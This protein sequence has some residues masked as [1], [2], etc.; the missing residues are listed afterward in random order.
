MDHY[1]DLRLGSHLSGEEVQSAS[2]IL[3]D[4]Y[5]RWQTN[6]KNTNPI[7]TDTSPE[8]Y[9]RLLV[10]HQKEIA[11]YY[12]KKQMCGVF[13]HSLSPFYDQYP[14]RKLSY[15]GVKPLQ[16]GFRPLQMIFFRYAQFMREQGEDVLITSD[17]DQRTLNSLL[18]SV[19]F[20]EVV[21][22]NETYYLLSHLLFRR[23]FSAAKVANDFVIDEI[24]TCDGK[25]IRR[26]KK[27]LKLQTTPMDFY[28][29]Y[30]QQQAKRVRRSIPEA[31]REQLFS[32]LQQADRGMYFISD[33]TSVITNPAEYEEG[34]DPKSALMGEQGA[35][36]IDE[37]IVPE[38]NVFYL[39]PKNEAELDRIAAKIPI[40][41]GFFD[42]LTF[43]FKTLSSFF[44][45]TGALPYE[46]N[47]VLNRD[48]HQ[49]IKLR[50]TD[51]L[52]GLIGPDV[53]LLEGRTKVFSDGLERTAY[54]FSGPYVDLS[55]RRFDLRKDK[56]VE[57]IF[58][59]RGDNPAPVIYVGK[60]IYE[61]LELRKLFDEAQ[62][63]QTPV[64][65][66]DMGN[67][68]TPWVSEN[69]IRTHGEGNP[70]FSVINIRDYYQIPVMLEDLG[71]KTEWTL[72]MRVR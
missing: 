62:A 41:P 28:A 24:I 26:N 21:D 56:M 8:V 23:V 37:C 57:K 65:V 47:A 52:E 66:L 60:Q 49:H 25:A 11:L 22:R 20:R 39:L 64:L 5:S 13:V 55:N 9:A 4:A 14:V 51:M 16:R 46:V 63:R 59:I 1:F 10:K 53:E 32:A 48:L 61:G 2:R 35:E 15:L 45:A 12:E 43:C 72:D 38:E 34:F 67:K 69:L 58:E 7:K 44:V 71:L 68:I 36:C 42:F 31:N 70:F 33:F 18:E 17:L 3:S 6:P 54:R 40:Q 27:L 30:C 19:G 50:Y 29:L